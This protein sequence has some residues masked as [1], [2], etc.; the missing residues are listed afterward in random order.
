MNNRITASDGSRKEKITEQGDVIKKKSDDP[1]GGWFYFLISTYLLFG[2]PWWLRQERVCLQFR[3]PSFDPWLR[4]IPWRREWHPTPVFLPRQSGGSRGVGRDWV[5]MRSVQR[6]SPRF[7]RWTNRSYSTGC[8]SVLGPLQL[9][10]TCWTTVFSLPC[11]RHC[12]KP[13][14]CR[15]E[16]QTHHPHSLSR[17][18]NRGEK[19]IQH[20]TKSLY[21]SVSVMT[22]VP[23]KTRTIRMQGRAGT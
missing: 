3:R 17:T 7:G 15:R 6:L 2:L 23:K 11:A 14:R 16:Q 4:K 5:R 22:G 9:L 10:P 20:R 21:D 18:L 19:S 8:G 13:Q 12:S 1:W